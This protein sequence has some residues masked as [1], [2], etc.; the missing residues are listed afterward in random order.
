MK[1]ERLSA[2]FIIDWQFWILWTKCPIL[3]YKKA[4][5]GA[6]CGHYEISRS[7]VDSSL[8]YSRQ[9]H[10]FTGQ[11]NRKLN[12]SYFIRPPIRT[13][14]EKVAGVFHQSSESGTGHY[15]L[16]SRLYCAETCC[17]KGQYWECFA[18]TNKPLSE[19]S[20]VLC[21]ALSSLRTQHRLFYFFTFSF[22][23]WRQNWLEE[24]NPGQHNTDK[25][26]QRCRS[27][28][29][30]CSL[31]SAAGNSSSV[32]EDSNNLHWRLRLDWAGRIWSSPATSH[33]LIVWTGHICQAELSPCCLGAAAGIAH[34]SEVQGVSINMLTSITRV[35]YRV[36]D[37]RM[38]MASAVFSPDCAGR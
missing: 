26:R 19:C 1:L 25:V 17:D 33:H 12:F 36:C 29:V 16:Q 37:T 31:R 15:S 35:K 9:H 21:N 38:A 11:T 10:Q 7:P 23:P 30:A 14:S 6:F 13:G 8:P 5:V 22:Q 28:S 4:L 3:Y 32:N 20:T 18:E 24:H 34:R 2:K 27:A